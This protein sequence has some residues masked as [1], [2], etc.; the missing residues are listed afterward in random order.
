MVKNE[1]KIYLLLKEAIEHF[2]E[3]KN[4]FKIANDERTIVSRIAHHIQK[5]LNCKYRGE[6][7]YYHCGTEIS[8]EKNNWY[9]D[10]EAS[11]SFISY[12]F[13]QCEEKEC[14]AYRNL[15]N[16]AVKRRKK[17]DLSINDREKT[18]CLDLEFK[19]KKQYT[20]QSDIDRLT[21]LTCKSDKR[22]SACFVELH[23][24]PKCEKACCKLY[25][26]EKGYVIKILRANLK[27]RTGKKIEWKDVTNT[28]YASRNI[29]DNGDNILRTVNSTIPQQN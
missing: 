8:V 5:L 24:T 25:Y 16:K 28:P 1:P 17:I 3:E 10:L 29:W 4:Y 21:C 22:K 18:I 13:N 26:I 20:N 2:T 15:I 6:H 9:C 7:F 12:L 11:A 14:S 19:T 27:P 23:I